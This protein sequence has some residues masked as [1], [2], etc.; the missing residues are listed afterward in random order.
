MANTPNNVMTPQNAVLSYVNLSAAT[1]SATRAPL[2]LATVT[3]A[4][5]V[6][7]PVVPQVPAAAD[8]KISKI[9]IRGSST[10]MTAPTV[11]QNVLVWVSDGTTVILRDEIVVSA[12]TPSTTEP[13][14]FSS[15][16]Y[17]DFVIPAG[18]ALYMS[19][20]VTTTAATTALVATIHG[21]SM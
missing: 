13:S 17:D 12:V 6:Y 15:I 11:A 16:I 21:A 7:F 4:T 1:A 19:T 18:Y 14:F 2:A 8:L 3:G 20:T 10:S 9:T 5:T